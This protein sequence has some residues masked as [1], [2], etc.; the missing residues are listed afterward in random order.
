MTQQFRINPDI[1][2]QDVDGQTILLNPDTGQVFG[3]DRVSTRVW[4]LVEEK[5]DLGAIKAQMLE[6]FDVD[7][8]QLS[9]DLDVYMSQLLEL[10]LVLPDGAGSK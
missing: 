5:S 7:E 1:I 10:E 2:L 8:V 6:D 9:K 4:E 3:L